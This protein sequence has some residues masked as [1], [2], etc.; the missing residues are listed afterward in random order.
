MHLLEIEDLSFAYQKNSA[1]LRGLRLH[2]EEGQRVGIRGPSG[3]GKSTLLRLIAGLER[4]A[5]GSIMINGKIVAGT[6]W[7]PPHRRAVSMVFQSPALW[8]HLTVEK[9]LA[10]VNPDAA[11]CR[12]MTERLGLAGLSKRRPHELSGGEARRAAI[13]R[14]LLRPH[15]LLLMDE[16][17][18]HLDPA[19]KK[20]ILALLISLTGEQNSGLIYVTHDESEL[21]GLVDV[22]YTMS[23][24]VLHEP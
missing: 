17:L 15:A 16:P 3:C 6:Q 21:P 10:L 7:A 2:V 8:S 24:G 18:I 9:T 14:A 1:V 4:P 13:A 22:T 12:E 19:L 23:G 11:Q 5:A 20:E